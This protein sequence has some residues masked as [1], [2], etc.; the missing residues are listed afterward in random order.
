MIWFKLGEAYLKDQ[1]YLPATKT[2]LKGIQHYKDALPSDS[3][4]SVLFFPLYL[5]AKASFKLD[6]FRD[7]IL[8]YNESRGFTT[9]ASPFPIFYSLGECYFKQ[10]EDL[11]QQGL[12]GSS[13][14]SLNQGLL[15]LNKA[16]DL[17]AHVLGIWKLVGDVLLLFSKLSA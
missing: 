14:T 13:A 3:N 17:N 11:F 4:S 5:L 15:V 9:E 8:Y 7:A 16:L 1:R 2:L 6:K 12:F 10:A